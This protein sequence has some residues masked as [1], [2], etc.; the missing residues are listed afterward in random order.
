MKYSLF[1]VIMSIL[2]FSGCSIKESAPTPFEYKIKTINC[3]TN[4]NNSEKQLL[5]NEMVKQKCYLLRLTSNLPLICKSGMIGY[6][7][8]WYCRY[9]GYM[10][11]CKYND[12]FKDYFIIRNNI[13]K[14]VDK[15]KCYDSGRQ[16]KCYYVTDSEN[17]YFNVLKRLE[18]SISLNFPKELKRYCRYKI[19]LENIRKEIINKQNNIKV[20]FLNKK[21]I[22]YKDEIKKMLSYKIYNNFPE[23]TD[24]VVS[25]YFNYYIN[26]NY[27]NF[28]NAFKIYIEPEARYRQQNYSFSSIYTY[29]SITHALFFKF[30][31][32]EISET[33]YKLPNNIVFKYDLYFNFTPNEFK[34]EDSYIKIF[35]YYDISTNRFKLVFNN[36]SNQFITI[37][38]VVY[39]YNNNSYNLNIKPFVIP[40]KSHKK[41]QNLNISINK[42]I[43]VN[44]RHQNIK[45]GLAVSYKIKNLNIKN[46]L[47]KQRQINFEKL[48]LSYESNILKFK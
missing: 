39:Y 6:H 45:V 35:L 48:F 1:L 2:F 24:K 13:I 26:K 46:T 14:K 31:P 34:I 25:F 27:S 29:Y 33:Y 19:A 5:L 22:L 37:D 40:P 32:S 7:T 20:S 44:D 38:D 30:K 28:K 12:F 47:F 42:F 21:N 23:S 9:I 41:I 17:N 16:T 3:K 11:Y 4:I 8:R 36:L 18:K 15:S 10:T 43:K